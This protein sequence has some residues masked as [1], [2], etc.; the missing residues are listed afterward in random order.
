MTD[1][2]TDARPDPPFSLLSAADLHLFNEGTHQQLH[3]HLG[4]HPVRVGGRDAVWFGVWAPS[5]RSVAVIGD[6][7]GWDA[8]VALAARGASGIWEGVV[9]ELS[10]GAHFGELA[11]LDPAPRAVT[12]RAVTPMVLAALGHRMFKV[13]LREVP[14]LSA[15]LLA[16]LASELRDARA[17]H[18]D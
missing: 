2:R 17:G 7:V 16:S 3:R 9:D 10:P 1:A 18:G 5:A 11:L 6:A 14:A 13:L 12:V 8:G 15:Q 4:A